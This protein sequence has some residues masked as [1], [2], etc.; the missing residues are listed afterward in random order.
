MEWLDGLMT[1]MSS[2]GVGAITGG[3]FGWL[4]RR[5]DRKLRRADQEFE[6]NRIQ[7][8]SSAD[9]TAIEAR[10]FEVSQVTKSKFGDAIKSAV[11]PII[12]G[13]LLYMTYRILIELEKI[14]GG[15]SSLPPAEA[16]ELYRGITLNII[17]L[18]AT[19]VSW[20]FASRPS[21]VNIMSTNTRN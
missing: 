13:A 12:T 20:W 21:S 18:T 14:T 8:Q 4:N 15:I 16:A 3:L 1:I 6:L 17:S 11:R 5:E 7:A 2:S 19:A 10:A 9:T